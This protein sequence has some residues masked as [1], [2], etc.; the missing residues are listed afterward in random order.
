MAP[1]AG[2]AGRARPAPAPGRQ[3]RNQVT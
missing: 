1:Q 3:S 2:G